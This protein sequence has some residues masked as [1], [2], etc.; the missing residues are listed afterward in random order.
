VLIIP[1]ATRGK[2]HAVVTR[3]DFFRALAEKLGDPIDEDWG[4]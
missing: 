1:I 4:E 2:V 3:N